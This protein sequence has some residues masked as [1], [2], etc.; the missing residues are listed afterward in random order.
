MQLENNLDGIFCRTWYKSHGTSQQLVYDQELDEMI[1]CGK[2]G[3]FR[4]SMADC[5][6][7]RDKFADVKRILEAFINK[8]ISTEEVI[9]IAFRH[10]DDKRVKMAV[11]FVI[12][13]LQYIFRY[14]DAGCAEMLHVLTQELYY[15]QLLERGFVPKKYI[16]EMLEILEN[17]IA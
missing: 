16:L 8:E 9:F 15:H 12:N 2:L 14:R 17:W 13:A 7:S 5:L 4:H 1:G 11:W 3:D 10:Y 6:A